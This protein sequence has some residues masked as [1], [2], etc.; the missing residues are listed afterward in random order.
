[1]KTHRFFFKYKKNFTGRQWL[2]N[3]YLY[4]LI[5]ERGKLVSDYITSFR[6]SELFSNQD[7]YDFTKGDLYYM[8]IFKAATVMY[9][10]PRKK[11]LSTLHKY[12]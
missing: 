8:R 10:T 9:T 12:V 11:L 2:F 4:K 1:M 7:I 3:Y 6:E 5:Y